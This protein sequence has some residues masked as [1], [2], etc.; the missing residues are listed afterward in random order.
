M[1]REFVLE[2][3]D[4]VISSKPIGV[5]EEFIDRCGIVVY[6]SSSNFSSLQGEHEF[7]CGGKVGGNCIGARIVWLFG[8][9]TFECD[10]LTK[11]CCKSS[12]DKLHFSLFEPRSWIIEEHYER[13][14]EWLYSVKLMLIL[15]DRRQQH[16]FR[17]G[18]IFG[19]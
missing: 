8:G 5:T 1:I 9:D 18:G 14:K 13:S 16:F 10:G 7:D 6:A 17:R 12:L 4:S 3:V 15:A 19:V 2:R 11:P